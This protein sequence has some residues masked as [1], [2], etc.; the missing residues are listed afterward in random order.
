MKKFDNEKFNLSWVTIK[1]EN[2]RQSS[3]RILEDGKILVVGNLEHNTVF[4][5][6]DGKDR[7]IKYL[8]GN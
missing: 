6:T 3:L 1:D 4:T 8:S 5:V 2:G 7:L